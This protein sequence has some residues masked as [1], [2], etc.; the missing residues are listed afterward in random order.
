MEYSKFRSLLRRMVVVPIVATAALAGLLLW[1]TFDLNQSLQWVDHTDRVIDQSGHLL[2]LLVDMQSSTRGYVAI[3]D[4]AFLQPFLEGTNRFDSEY[5][6]LYGLLADSPSQQQRL[7]DFHV[8]FGAWK[9]DATQI[10]A[11]RRAGRADPTLYE[12]RQE[13]QRMDALREQIAEFQS[14]EQGLRIGRAQAAHLRWN[15]MVTSCLGLG[16]G[17]GVFLAFFTRYNVE[18]LGTRLLQSE[19]RW[20]ATLGSIG[21]AVIATDSEGRVTF[22]NSVAAALTGWPLN[23]ALNQPIGNVLRLI[24]EKSGMTADNEVLRVL[25]EK[26]VLAVANHVDLVTRD[27]REIAVEHSA[28]PILAAKGEVIGVVLIFRDV[29][30]RR[31]EQIATAEQAALLELTQ[32]PVFVIDLE[33]TV[34]FWSR[35]AEAMLGYLKAQAAGKVSHDLLCTEFPQPLAEIKAELMRAGH[36]EG[37]IVTTAQNGRRIVMSSRWALQWGKRDQAPRVLVINSDITQRKQG[38]ESLILQKEQLR[39]LAERLQL[40]REEDRK[41]VARDLHDQIGQILTAIKMDLTWVTRHLPEAKID[42]LDR[43]RKRA[44]RLDCIQ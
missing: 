41:Q 19:E 2:K 40:V 21:E 11:L 9:S 37:D 44:K 31:Q 34:L 24:N 17:F 38:E 25:K 22:L 29:A 6:A 3:G 42:V 32:D 36:W 12:N 10:I 7:N 23:E 33:G 8:A 4:Q 5:S 43:E 15:L 18:K 13:K 27:G 1:E 16:L 26:Q 35:G 20:T 30:E 39:A 14:V 28:A